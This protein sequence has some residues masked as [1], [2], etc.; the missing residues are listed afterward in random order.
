MLKRILVTVALIGVTAASFGQGTVIFD[1]RNITTGQAPVTDVGV[2][3]R[4]SGATVKAQLFSA[5]GVGVASNS[6]SA[7]GVPVPFRTGINAGFVETRDT[8]ANP[9]DPPNMVNQ[10]VAVTPTA[11]G[12]ATVQMRAWDAAFP[13]YDAAI[14]GLGRYGWSNIIPIPTTGGGNPA[15]PPSELAG[16]QGFGLVVVPEPSTFAL[17]ALGLAAFLFRRRK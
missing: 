2:T 13:T 9:F 12:P 3:N 7:A 16:L 5:A 6:L 11:N 1:N 14:A 4:V 15:L 10:V 17:A 8:I